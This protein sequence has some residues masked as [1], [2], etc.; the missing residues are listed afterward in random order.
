MKNKFLLLSALLTFYSV[1]LFAQTPAKPKLVVGIVVDQ[2]RF[3]YLYRFQSN[4]GKDGFNRLMREGTNF[5][6]AHFNYVPTPVTE[7]SS[8]Q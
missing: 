4:Y 2:M 1:A 8:Q 3:D 5:T 7:L 6:Y